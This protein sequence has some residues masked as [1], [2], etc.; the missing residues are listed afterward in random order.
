MPWAAASSGARPV[1]YCD[2]VVAQQAQ[3]GHVGAGR[4][5]RRARGWPGRR[6]PPRRP[7]PSPACAAASSGVLPP[8]DSCGSSAQPSGMM[9]AYFIVKS[10]TVGA[11]R[12]VRIQR[13]LSRGPASARS[14]PRMNGSRSIA[15]MRRAHGAFGRRVGHDHQRD[16]AVGLPSSASCW[17][18]EAIEMLCWPSTPAISAS[19]PGCPRR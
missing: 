8:S 3:V 13:R 19:T 18:T 2:G 14:A 1:K 4:Q 10:V 17:M 12:S 6:R 15:A 5:V 16:D 11:I 7:R 9:M